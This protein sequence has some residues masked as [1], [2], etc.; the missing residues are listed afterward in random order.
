[1]LG[2]SEEVYID[3][4][5]LSDEDEGLNFFIMFFYYDG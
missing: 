4:T 1:M 2:F 5:G 3:F